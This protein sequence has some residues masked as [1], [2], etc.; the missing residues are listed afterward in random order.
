MFMTPTGP[1]RDLSTVGGISRR[2]SPP[3]FAVA[4][5]PERPGPVAQPVFKTG[6]VV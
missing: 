1:G 5:T 6:E 4:F 2:P 3:S